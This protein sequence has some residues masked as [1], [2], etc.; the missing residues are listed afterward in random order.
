M[1]PGRAWPDLALLEL[2]VSVSEHGS[3]G[4]GARAVGMAQPNASRAVARFERQVG[5]TLLRRSPRGSTLTAQGTVVVDW[6]RT[7]LDAADQLMAGADALRAGAGTRLAV[8][9]SMTVAEH[10]VPE[11]LAELRRRHPDLRVALE[12]LNSHDVLAG[13]RSGAYAVGFVESP[14]VP[15]GLHRAVV[16]RDDLVVVV[17]PSHPWRRR[18]RPLT[19]EELATTPL[20]VR[21]AGSGTRTALETALAGHEI[22]APALALNSNAAVRVSVMSGAGPAVLSALAVEAALRS[23]ELH[24]VPVT[25]LDLT[26]LLRAVWSGGRRLDGPG[27]D[28]VQ[29]ARQSPSG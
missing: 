22:A 2:L 12:V 7:V 6:A 1:S 5:L 14:G 26:R 19:A 8:A 11:W 4:A 18:R 23:G 28:L 20:V 13:V 17:D 15:S 24:R 21:E 3:L 10:L 25:G 29:I 27:G 9:A 16:G